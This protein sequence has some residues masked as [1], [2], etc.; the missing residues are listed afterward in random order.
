MERKTSHAARVASIAR[1]SK[2][3]IVNGKLDE[4]AAQIEELRRLALDD[5]LLTL[6]TAELRFAQQDWAE[7]VA[8]YRAALTEEPE[9]RKGARRAHMAAAMHH[10]ALGGFDEAIEHA[11]EAARLEP[12]QAGHSIFPFFK[13][14]ILSDVRSQ[15]I[16]DFLKE[17][18]Q[19]APEDPLLQ[20]MKRQAPNV[21]RMDARAPFLGAIQRDGYVVQETPGASAVALVL[22]GVGG[23]RRFPRLASHFEKIGTHVVYLAD[24]RGL[25]FAGGIEQLGRNHEETMVKLAEIC[26]RLNAE[27]LITIGFSAGGFAAV[28]YA[29]DLGAT[30]QFPSRVRRP[31]RPKTMKRTGAASTRFSGYVGSPGSIWETS[32]LCSSVTDLPCNSSASSAARWRSTAGMPRGSP[33]FRAWPWPRWRAMRNTAPASAPSRRAPSRAWSRPWRAAQAPTKLRP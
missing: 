31:S 22:G 8:L 26:D 21:G 17:L 14:L 13:K 3:L 7:A 12:E 28:R 18:L 25:I 29:L 1:S 32:S 2:R 27:R 4:A 15:Q 11:T 24:R 5:P 16:K 9:A 23:A 19:L 20:R 6:R 30:A 10:L 33:T